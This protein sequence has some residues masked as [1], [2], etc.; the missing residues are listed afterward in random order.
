MIDFW[1]VRHGETEENIKGICQGQTPGTL[2]TNGYMQ[3]KK[4]GEALQDIKFQHIYSSDLLRTMESSKAIANFQEKTQIIPTKLLRERYLASWQGK[5]FPK[6]WDCSDSSLPK[7]A[8]TCED[9]LNRVRKFMA[10]LI[11]NHKNEAML[12]V[13]HGG[14]IRAFWTVLQNENPESYYRWESPLNTSISRFSINESGISKCLFK[15]SIEHLDCNFE[16]DKNDI[17]WQL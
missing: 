13:S 8:E 1:L 15:N 17:T 3:A 2:T 16:L 7:D 12:A 4:V 5:A 11:L 14:L 9:L 10:M 6:D